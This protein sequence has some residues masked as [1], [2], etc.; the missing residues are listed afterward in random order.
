MIR[1]LLLAVVLAAVPARAFDIIKWAD[2]LANRQMES[3]K[4][5]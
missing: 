4:R 1:F 2:D 3:W 5:E